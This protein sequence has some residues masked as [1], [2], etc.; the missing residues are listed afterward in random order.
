[1][2]VKILVISDTHGNTDILNR[3][4]TDSSPVDIIIHCGDGVRDI[5]RAAIPENC[6]VMEV[7]G[8]TDQSFFY[9]NE[10]ILFEEIL[11][12][13]VMITHGHRFNVKTGL[14]ELALHAKKSDA[15]VVIFGHTHKQLL[16]YG[17]PLLFNPGNLSGGDYGLIHASEESEWIFEHKRAEK[18]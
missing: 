13:T 6:V 11:G 10:E 2:P 7:S 17:S 15:A 4:I 1:M 5:R 18:K 8:N 14:N 3:V 12:T 16:H 9:D